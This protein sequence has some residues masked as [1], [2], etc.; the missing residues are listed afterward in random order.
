MLKAI[1]V[2]DEPIVLT[3]LMKKIDWK[4][5]GIE[6]AGMARDGLSALRLVRQAR[7]DL[8]LTDIRMPGLD[9]LQLIEKVMAEFPQT[10][11][12]VFSGFNEFEYARRAIGLGVLDYLEKPITMT[13]VEKAIVRALEKIEKDQTLADLKVKWEERLEE[14]LEKATLDLLL[15]GDKA[16]PNWMAVYGEKNSAI[17]AVTV[18]AFDDD[19]PSL[20]THPSYH[21]IEV[22]NGN[23]RLS[24]I[25][26]VSNDVSAFEEQLLLWNAQGR[27]GTSRTYFSIGDARRSYKEAVRALR[28]GTFLNESGRLRIEDVERKDGQSFIDLRKHQEAILVAIR[29]GDLEGMNWALRGFQAWIKEWKLPPD[30]VEGEL[31]KLSSLCVDAAAEMARDMKGLGIYRHHELHELLSLE[32]MF[33]WMRS[34]LAELVLWAT[35]AKHE[36]KHS[37]LESV[38]EYIEERYAQDLSL[39]EL[40]ALVEL[41]PA[42]LSLL[43]KERM[44]VSYR[45]YLTGIR[46]E[47]AKILLREGKRVNEVY[48]QVGYINQRHFAETFKRIVGMTPVYYRELH[49]SGRRFDHDTEV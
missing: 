18:L 26:H 30:R 28:Y 3:G 19:K 10:K 45:K 8:I 39:Q 47:K 33:E 2:D 48:G 34:K 46:I 49:S 15:I 16:L 43:F 31:L 24:V 44:G 42:Y 37:S 20:P 7:P 36:R 29:T 12:I 22:R 40:A 35:S 9:G 21:E 25:F 17:S 13:N 41:H 27:Y 32:E 23:E 4:R 1:V 6:L 14:R 38:L 5:H 11:F